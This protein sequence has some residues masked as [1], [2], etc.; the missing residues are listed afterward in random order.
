MIKIVDVSQNLL[1]DKVSA[2]NEFLSLIN[3][4]VSHEMRNPINSILN[5]NLNQQTILDRIKHYIEDQQRALRAEEDRRSQQT[6]HAQIKWLKE[7]FED[8]A[9]SS[10]LQRS[11]SK[12]L[13]HQISCMLDFAQI[14]S[15]KFQ[16]EAS[17]FDVYEALI[18]QME[19][20]DVQAKSQD[21]DVQI[22]FKGF[23]DY[24]VYTDKQR[25]QQVFLN[26]YSNALKFT[27]QG[28][29][30]VTVTRLTPD[31]NF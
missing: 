24:M 31:T 29:V 17:Y 11:S 19:L 27:S 8:I 14:S 15:S 2:Q 3:A 22:N 23:T 25:L 7:L 16:K 26:L 21:I 9:F 18:E 20:L 1:Y 6:L 28:S 13:N 30:Q 12:L 10:K 5:Q 4:T